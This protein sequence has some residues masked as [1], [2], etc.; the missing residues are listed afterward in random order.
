MY[1]IGSTTATLFVLVFGTALV[2]AL[3]RQR[4]AADA[5]LQREAL[6]HVTFDKA[7][8]GI[9]HNTLDGRFLRAN[10]KYCAR[11]HVGVSTSRSLSLWASARSR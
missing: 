9:S 4:R 1:L 6:Y 11:S 10:A 7:A 8:V 5:A 3:R 2:V